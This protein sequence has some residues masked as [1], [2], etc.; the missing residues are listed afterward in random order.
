MNR[1]FGFFTDQK[2]WM[3]RHKVMLLNLPPGQVILIEPRANLKTVTDDAATATDVADAA[4]VAD[5]YAVE[6][7]LAAAADVA[8]TQ[9]RTRTAPWE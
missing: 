9:N 6:V 1:E 8:D 3:V 4:D 7:E 2:N 5:V